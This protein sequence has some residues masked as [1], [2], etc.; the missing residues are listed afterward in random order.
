M[1]FRSIEAL[2]TDSLIVTGG[3]SY[4]NT[5]I[6]DDVLLSPGCGASCTVLDPEVLVGD[7]VFFN[8]SGNSFPNAPEWIANVTARYGVP[9][10][11]GELYVFTDW[12][13]KGDTNFFLY[14]SV[15]FAED[16][17]W[18]GGLRAGWEGNNG[19]ALSAFVR[20]LTDE[21]VLE[22]GIDFNNLTGFVN[23]PRTWGVEIGY[24]F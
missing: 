7:D 13:Y 18:L 10:Q 23:E 1:L 15:E 22:G 16:G 2:F 11:N 12:A 21:L 17:Y 6:K 5:E 14:E 19:V 9:F 4:N 24:S 8:I 20:N 3:L